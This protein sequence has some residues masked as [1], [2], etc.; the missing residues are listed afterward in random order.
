MLYVFTYCSLKI[1][2]GKIGGDWAN[3][4]DRDRPSMV[5]AP[6]PKW[7]ALWLIRLLS[8]AGIIYSAAKNFFWHLVLRLKNKLFKLLPYQIIIWRYRYWKKTS[9]CNDD[10]R[11]NFSSI[12]C[13]LFHHIYFVNS[14]FQQLGKTSSPV[15]RKKLG[16]LYNN[17][18]KNHH[19]SQLWLYIKQ[20]N[21]AINIVLWSG[22]ININI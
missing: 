19:E 10:H 15:H 4:K 8:V 3:Y 17:N 6:I 16:F 14:H 22:W 9:P 5:K 2:H 11:I 13:I 20:F 7:V 1:P 12:K 21:K 18:K